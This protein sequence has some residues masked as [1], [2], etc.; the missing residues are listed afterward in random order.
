IGG[1]TIAA[2]AALTTFPNGSDQPWILDFLMTVQTT[3]ATGTVI[4]QGRGDFYT[5]A[6]TTTLNS[7]LNTATTTIDTTGTLALDVTVQWST[8]NG[9]NSATCTNLLVGICG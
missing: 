9:A 2:T 8:S 7:L 4:G 3:G 6:A 1:S 5:S